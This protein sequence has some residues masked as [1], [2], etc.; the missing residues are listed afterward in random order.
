[1]KLVIFIRFLHNDINWGPP[2]LPSY[3][4]SPKPRGET[5]DVSLKINILVC[6]TVKVTHVSISY[7]INAN[8]LCLHIVQQNKHLQHNL[9]L[10]MLF[11]NESFFSSWKRSLYCEHP[12]LRCLPCRCSLSS[13]LMLTILL[14]TCWGQRSQNVLTWFQEEI[15][16]NAAKCWVNAAFPPRCRVN[17]LKFLVYSS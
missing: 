4:T 13:Y 5:T 12:P 17:F 14:V 3:G 10:P 2:Y 7:L 1:M 11:I 6:I 9:S 8:H 15:S 16:L